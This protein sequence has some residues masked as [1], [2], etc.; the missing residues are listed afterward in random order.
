MLFELTW[1]AESAPITVSPTRRRKRSTDSSV[2][3][4]RMIAA[5]TI[6]TGRIDENSVA[7]SARDRTTNSSTGDRTKKTSRLRTY[8]ACS[9]SSPMRPT[10]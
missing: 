8:R 7:T 10:M 1:A 9:P 4:A 6:E 2:K 3:T 5:V